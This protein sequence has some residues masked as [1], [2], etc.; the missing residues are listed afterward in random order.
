MR[1]HFLEQ[2]FPP[3]VCAYPSLYKMRVF[4]CFS[5]CLIRKCVG[6]VQVHTYT[7]TKQSKRYVLLKLAFSSGSIAYTKGVRRVIFTE[8]IFYVLC[9]RWYIQLWCREFRW[10][11]IY[12]VWK[13][14]YYILCIICMHILQPHFCW[15]ASAEKKQR[16]IPCAEKQAAHLIIGFYF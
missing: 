9:S 16:V 5:R 4:R 3:A 6:Y 15:N 14:L 11:I 1:Y 10:W 12:E 13:I 8:S 2:R 7:Y